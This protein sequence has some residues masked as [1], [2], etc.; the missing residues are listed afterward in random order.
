[1]YFL[2]KMGIFHGYVSLLEG[3]PIF[4]CKDRNGEKWCILRFIQTIGGYGER[5]LM[6][7]KKTLVGGSIFCGLK[8]SSPLP[9]KTLNWVG[10]AIFTTTV[11]FDIG[12]IIRYS[13]RQ[14][15][16]ND[17]SFQLFLRYCWWF[18]NPANHTTWDVRNLMKNGD[19]LLWLSRIFLP[20]TVS[21]TINQ[22]MKNRWLW[23]DFQKKKM[24]H[25][26]FQL[27][28]HPGTDRGCSHEI[29]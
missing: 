12:K 5:H 28:L 6:A 2:L 10:D 17:V 9:K 27:K 22:Y 25:F 1:M 23:L 29:T 3:K 20:S 14:K 4:F 26:S 24:H 18:R 21:T 11:G 19:K 8:Y 15:T 13:H 16:M 7:S